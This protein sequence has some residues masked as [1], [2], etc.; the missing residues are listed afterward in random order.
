MP[1]CPKCD[2]EMKKMAKQ[3]LKTDSPRKVWD[4]G[5]TGS[6]TTTTTTTSGSD[7]NDVTAS[8]P[9]EHIES[10]SVTLVPYECPTCGFQESYRE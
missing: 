5:L 7:Y 2:I 1:K 4:L 10:K 9:P 8:L 6:G 3:P